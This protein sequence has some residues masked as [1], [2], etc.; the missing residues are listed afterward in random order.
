MG[1]MPLITYIWSFRLELSERAESMT[2][3]NTTTVSRIAAARALI[4]FSVVALE[5]PQ[6][7]FKDDGRFE[8]G[9]RPSV[10]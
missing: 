7:G 8:D 1:A 2:V 5:T 3:Q 6:R 4:P 10:L 9:I